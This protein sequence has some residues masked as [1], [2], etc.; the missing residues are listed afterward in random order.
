MPLKHALRISKSASRYIPKPI[1][2]TSSCQSRSII[3][4]PRNFPHEKSVMQLPPHNHKINVLPTKFTHKDFV[5]MMDHGGVEKI[6]DI[7][8]IYLPV[9]TCSLAFQAKYELYYYKSNFAMYEELFHGLTATGPIC[10]HGT[11]N[12]DY[13][14]LNFHYE[15]HDSNWQQKPLE[16]EGTKTRWKM[17]KEK[18]KTQLLGEEPPVV[19]WYDD[20]KPASNEIFVQDPLDKLTPIVLPFK[21]N[22]VNLILKAPKAFI[23]KFNELP[24][25]SQMKEKITQPKILL[26]ALY[27]IYRPIYVFYVQALGLLRLDSFDAYQGTPTLTNA[28]VSRKLLEFF[29]YP[30]GG[31]VGN[32]YN[33]LDATQNYVDSNINHQE[34]YSSPINWKSRYIQSYL[35]QG[36]ENQNWLRLFYRTARARNDAY[37]SWL[38][39][40]IKNQF[41]SKEYKNPEEYAQKVHRPILW[42]S[43][44]R[45]NGFKD[46]FYTTLR[47][48]MVKNTPAWL[49]NVDFSEIPDIK[50]PPE[51]VYG[52]ERKQS[53]YRKPERT[54]YVKVE[55]K[56]KHK[57]NPSYEEPQKKSPSLNNTEQSDKNQHKSNPSYEEPRKK[58]PS[59]NSTE[60]SDKNQHK[61]KPSFEEPRK[62]SPSLNS[63]ERSDKNQHKSKPSCEEPRKKS[64]SD[65]NQHKSK[66]SCEE[67][68]KKSPS[69]NS[70]ERSDKNQHK[71]KPSFE[72]PRKKSPSLN[73][74]ER[75]DK[76]QHIPPKKPQESQSQ[77][78]HDP[79]GYYK[80]LG[81]DYLTLIPDDGIIKLAFSSTL[82][83]IE[84]GYIGHMH[85]SSEEKQ[86]KAEKI[87]KLIEARE[88]LIKCK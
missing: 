80:I 3:Y 49:K 69:L 52:E 37:F 5:K 35:G 62:K 77:R 61:S 47:E 12:N 53:S 58:S 84:S 28:S 54:A 29:D 30:N 66:P 46:L 71:S 67:P 19:N 32:L 65:K 57:S 14:D 60:R 9:W 78:L 42:I 44:Y 86:E 11:D 41:S 1:H 81:L 13:K 74:A 70:T 50:P 18:M 7:K 43:H 6:F 31:Y 17:F 20:L 87:R 55:Q 59:L 26:F 73:S 27:P 51:R 38:R 4:E 83:K 16:I 23:G 21:T 15:I 68:R 85:L 8:K 56:V 24:V 2:P 39:F 40:Q 34:L 45:G 64:P 76:N 82:R 63:A 25:K 75:S 22:P 79:K 36:I 33:V 48:H 10:I 88:A 72:E